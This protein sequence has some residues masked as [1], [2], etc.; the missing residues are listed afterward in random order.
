MTRTKSVNAYVGSPRPVERQGGEGWV[1]AALPGSITSFC[2]R[3]LE[4]VCVE[5]Y[6]V[7]NDANSAQ[8]AGG[9]RKSRDQDF[10]LRRA[11]EGTYVD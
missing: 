8:G 7:G 9:F 1:S 4:A 6:A 3:D 2:A 11:R 5:L 10:R